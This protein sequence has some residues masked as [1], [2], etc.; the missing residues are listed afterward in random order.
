MKCNNG[1]TSRDLGSD[2]DRRAT[3]EM[4]SSAAT[5]PSRSAGFPG[6]KGD[7][8]GRLPPTPRW[9]PPIQ[10]QRM[11]FEMCHFN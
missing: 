6:F 4:R 5:T 9:M 1:S 2:R 10:T 7:A 11:R 8:R 3:H